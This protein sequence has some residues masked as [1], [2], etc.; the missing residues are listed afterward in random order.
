MLTAEILD[1]DGR[2]RAD[3]FMALG[4]LCQLQI[5][6]ANLQE[7]LRK[8]GLTQLTGRGQKQTP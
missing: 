6:I 5:D 7:T 8:T 3:G 1:K 2:L 4:Q